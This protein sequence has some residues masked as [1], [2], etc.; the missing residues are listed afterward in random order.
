MIVSRDINP[1]RDFYYLG[2]KIIEILLTLET[3]KADFFYVF[4][5]LNE[6]EKVSI[7]L[8]SLTLDWLFLLGAI[9]KLNK[10]KIIRCF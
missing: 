3:K 7:N 1:E 10:G 8:F 2:A 4:E 9:D 6:S 5:L